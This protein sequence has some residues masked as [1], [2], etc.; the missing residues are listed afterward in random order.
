V[1]FAELLKQLRTSAGMTQEGLAEA[2][3][4]SYRSISDL[5]RGI[6]LTARRE[7]A[8]L[9][10]DALGL[11]G[12]DRAFFEAVARGRGSVMHDSLGE[13]IL[14]PD[15]TGVAIAT[16]TLPRDIS[17]FTGR[18][19]ELAQLTN[20]LEGSAGPEGVVVAIHAIDGMAGIGKTTFAVR[21]AHELASRFPDG[22]IFLRLH[23]HTPGQHPVSASDALGT[24]LLT[25]GVPAPHIPPDME[26][27]ASLWRDRMST[28]KALL[29]L[30]D[31]TGTEHVRPLLPSGSGTLVLITSR[32]RL[33]GLPEALPL[34]L[35]TLEPGK[36]AELFARLVARA[37]VRT[38]DSGVINLVR[39]CGYLPLA[40][41]LMAGQ[42]KHHGTWTS[43]DLAIDLASTRDRL[44]AIHAEEHSVTAAFDLSYADLNIDQQQLFRRLGLQPG[45]D[46]DG[47]AAAA[48]AGTSLVA[49]AMQLEGLYSHHLIDEPVRGR[50]RFHDLIREHARSL[51]LTDDRAELNSSIDRL[52]SYYTHSVRA[53]DRHLAR[54]TPVRFPTIVYNEPNHAPALATRQD[55]VGWMDAERLNL[56]AAVDF[57]AHNDKLQFSIA[58]PAAMQG[59]LRT[60]GHWSQAVALHQRALDSAHRNS[61]QLGEA[62]ALTNMG[63][64]RY[65]MG[66]YPAATANLTRAAELFHGLDDQLGEANSI[67]TLGLVQRATGDHLG[68]VRNQG[69]ALKLY[70]A[71]GDLRGEAVA[72][73]DLGFAQYL[74]GDYPSAKASL[75]RALQ[76]YSDL[77]DQNG[78]ATALHFLGTVQ[79]VTEDYSESIASLTRSLALYRGTGT[80]WGEAN[81]LAAL[82]DVQRLTGESS[83]ANANL[84]QA[85]QLYRELGHRSGESETQNS[86]GELLQSSSDYENAR[87]HHEQALDIARRIAAPLEEARALEG[88][89]VCH[90]RCGQTGEGITLLRQALGIYEHVSSPRSHRVEKVLHEL[91]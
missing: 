81:A 26:A 49:T 88:I 82:G 20:V 47:Y 32:R 25:V 27:R 67:S 13:R 8:R 83:A 11:E 77:G 71:V 56:H 17:T 68:A 22:Q 9:L 51:G 37:D 60:Y 85:L 21:V 12:P 43:A 18:E 70:R 23:G 73:G 58:I 39:L 4:L 38:S 64:V 78:Q 33:T 90:I 29:V 42:L 16:R 62:A 3:G 34:T 14:A 75:T 69:R 19:R 45:A 72:L 66:D 50:F 86:I 89:G 10:A 24:L 65:L 61:D 31:A 6:N 35:D 36:A 76:L 57:A 79:S 30:D 15:A 87:S 54:R 55:A 74:I 2:A 5:E 84:A 80:P 41:S 44:G 40:I 48:L 91:G 59:F 7:T 63:D 46:V 1:S 28:K 52:L 53:A